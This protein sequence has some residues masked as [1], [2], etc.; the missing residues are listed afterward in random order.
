MS[1]FEGMPIR[2]GEDFPDAEVNIVALPHFK[3]EDTYFGQV[4]SQVTDYGG[5]Y[6][7]FMWMSPLLSTLNVNYMY[8]DQINAVAGA[9]VFPLMIDQPTAATHLSNIFP[10][11]FPLI[12][13]PSKVDQLLNGPPVGSCG[14]R[15]IGNPQ[16]L[17][18]YIM[19]SS[20]YYYCGIESFTPTADIELCRI[21]ALLGGNGDL[22]G[23]TIYCQIWSKS[24]NDLD[25][26]LA[27]ASIS[28]NAEI[29]GMTS[30]PFPFVFF[31]D[32]TLLNG[33]TYAIVVTMEEV[34]A[35]NYIRQYRG[36]NT[37]APLGTTAAW[38]S[39]GVR[40]TANSY[41]PSFVLYE[42]V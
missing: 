40:S 6:N 10:P 24:G 26:K 37:S 20:T 16:G 35:S 19:N 31:F 3:P 25:T 5:S 29:G 34:D 17:D 38:N 1:H 2:Y 27:E 11:V 8:N 14:K 30:Y 42:K 36:P 28:G 12:Y 18:N 15:V 13:S 41:E 7:K 33:V 22:T 9:K 4:S 21:S 23:K 39:S 32:Y